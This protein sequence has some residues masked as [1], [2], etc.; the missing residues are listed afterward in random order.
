[1]IAIRIINLINDLFIFLFNWD[2]LCL[3][4]GLQTILQFK[5]VI[6]F[7]IPNSVLNCIIVHTTFRII[8]LSV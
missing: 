5:S 7:H 2:I 6:N 8:Y 3:V 4:A 1:M